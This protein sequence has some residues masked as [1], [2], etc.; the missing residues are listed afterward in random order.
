MQRARLRGIS[1]HS[2]QQGTANQQQQYFVANAIARMTLL[3]STMN[4][5]NTPQAFERHAFADIFAADDD[6]QTDDGPPAYE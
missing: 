3:R 4:C 2:V 5:Y 6:E 1:Q